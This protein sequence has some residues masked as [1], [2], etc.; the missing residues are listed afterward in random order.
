V[1]HPN[2]YHYSVEYWT[3]TW[4]DPNTAVPLGVKTG[5]TDSQI[6]AD[7]SGANKVDEVELLPDPG[8][9]VWAGMLTPLGKTWVKK[10]VSISVIHNGDS[11]TRF[12]SIYYATAQATEQKWKQVIAT[13]KMYPYAAHPGVGTAFLNW[14]RSLYHYEQTNSN[15]FARWL[16]ISAGL[17]WTDM[18]HWHPGDTEPRQNAYFPYFFY[19]NQM[20]WKGVPDR[21]Q[22][23]GSPP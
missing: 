10:D 14:P 6:C 12:M 4:K 9:T 11:A 23:Q 3:G 1:G 22:P 13:A 5:F 7:F 18:T 2:F 16:V 19:A 20:P 15:T 21:P 8:F 17:Q